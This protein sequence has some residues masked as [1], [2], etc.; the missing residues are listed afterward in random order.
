MTRSW[1]CRRTSVA[2]VGLGLGHDD[3]GLAAPVAVDAEGDDVAGPHAVER[4]DGPLD[5]LGEDVAPADDDHVLDAAAHH[6]LAVERVGEVA[7]AQP[8]VVEQ[9]G[10]GVGALV[11]AGG[12]RRAADLELADLAVAQGGA[13]LGVD[14][15]DLEAGDRAAQQGEAAAA[16][17]A[18]LDRGRVALGL[19]DPPV[20]AVGDHAAHRLGERAGD[21]DLG[22][23]ERREHGAGPQPVAGA[24]LDERLDLVGVDRLGAVEGDAQ[25]GQVE[26]V[27]P[28]E[29]P[30]GEHVAEVRAG[31]GRAAVGRTATPSSGPAG[32]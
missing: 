11:V 29:R 12:H 8:A 2:V 1:T 23:A 6:Q 21:G 19:E 25:A 3:Q 5:V 30:G 24:G 15:A 7:G 28:V 16:V 26:L 14:D 27:G 4:A 31:G 10:V 18:G 20:D 17:G 22:H 9:V 32:P 13:G